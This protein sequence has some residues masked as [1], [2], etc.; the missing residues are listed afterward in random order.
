MVYGRETSEAHDSDSL[1]LSLTLSPPRRA[2]PNMVRSALTMTI[3]SACFWPGLL[4][5]AVT[6][7]SEGD[8]KGRGKRD[9]EADRTDGETKNQSHQDEK[10]HTDE[11]NELHTHVDVHHVCI[12][13]VWCR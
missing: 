11:K 1:F 9:D 7:V 4:A 6:E 2:R 12:I 10:K 3:S 13:F 8:Q 5:L